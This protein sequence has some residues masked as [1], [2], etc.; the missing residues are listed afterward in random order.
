MFL[1]P[2][3]FAAEQ[4]RP[5]GLSPFEQY[6]SIKSSQINPDTEGRHK[7]PESLKTAPVFL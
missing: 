1:G 7:K 3:F 5:D 4:A 6:Y 2:P